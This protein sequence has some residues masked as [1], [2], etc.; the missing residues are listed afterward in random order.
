L[1]TLWHLVIRMRR[2]RGLDLSRVDVKIYIL[3]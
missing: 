2:D 1:L 3:R